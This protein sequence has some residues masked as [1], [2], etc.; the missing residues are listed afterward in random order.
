MRFKKFKRLVS[1]LLAIFTIFSLIACNNENNNE[2]ETQP[3]TDK[4]PTA[5]VP[6]ED[7]VIVRGDLYF[8]EENISNACY[9]LKKAIEKAYGFIPEVVTDQTNAI[10]KKEILVG[11]TNRNA[12]KQ[13]Y[14]SL[15]I[16]DYG[17]T[18]ASQNT[19]VICGGTPEKTMEA[20]EK[21]CQDLLT[22]DGKKVTAQNPQLKTLT[23]FIEH[24]T[25]EYSSLTLNGVLWEDYTM[26][27]S[28]AEDLVGALELNKQLGQ[29]TGRGLP[30]ISLS[31]TTGN[32]ESVIRIGASYRN[33]MRANDL[34]GYLISNYVDEKGN[35]ICIDASKGQYPTAIKKLL[36]NA[37]E[38]VNGAN[39]N[40]QF[41]QETL[42]SVS[43]EYRNGTNKI[44]DYVH[45]MLESETTKEVANG[46]TYVE[47]L[48]YDDAGLP[49]RVYTLLVDT[50]LY[51]LSMGCSNDGYDKTV[52]NTQD[53]QTTEQHMQAAVNKGKNVLAGINADFFDILPSETTP[54]DYRPWGLTI[55]DGVIISKGEYALRPH[56]N[57]TTGNNRAFFGYTK[58][59]TPVIAME[60][61]YNT[62]AMLA[63]LETAVGGAYI[64]TDNGKINFFKYQHNIIHG[65]V[66]PRGLAG[67]REDGTVVLMV[68][69][70]RQPT[71]SNGAS[72]LQS[73]L[74]MQ[75]FGATDAIL[76]DCGGSSNLVLRDPASNVYTTANS[77]SDGKLREIYNSLLVIEK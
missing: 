62:D 75:R 68:I 69:D 2:Q 14:E 21:F 8:S 58:D 29:Y 59:G 61:E 41:D 30:I 18:V 70:G 64:L 63:T 13:M 5:F 74:L 73:S 60:S 48:Y 12:S 37:E 10:G 72:L 28:T 38:T 43:T 16:N 35:V 50:N 26:I 44:N 11:Y 32:E 15:G 27:V 25:Y 20:T 1:L 23:K 40:F 33:G 49:Y 51:K 36:E 6:T 54:G 45:W 77:P 66:D 24:D 67:Y 76:F 71:H 31:E 53:R 3:I 34:V 57:G 52:T 39:I 17:Y 55:K 42:Y 65:E 46:I 47:Q 56:L 7:F 19:I 4:M 9:L 22:Y